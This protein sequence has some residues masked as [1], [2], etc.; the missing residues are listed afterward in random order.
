T[1]DAASNHDG[2]KSPEFDRLCAQAD[3]TAD[4]KQRVELYNKAEDIAIQDAARVPI[5]YPVDQILVSPRVHGL[6]SNV[7]GQL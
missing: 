1:S 6:R 4:E 3:S 5:Y 2:Y 7:L